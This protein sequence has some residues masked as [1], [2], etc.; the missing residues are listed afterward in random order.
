MA[1]TK[2][3]EQN[4]P[5]R[6][7][8]PYRKFMSHPAWKVLEEALAELEANDDLELTTA[9]RYVVGFLIQVLVEKGL[10]FPQ[11]ADELGK[12]HVKFQW[13]L[14]GN[15]S[16]EAHRRPALPRRTNEGVSA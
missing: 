15:V 14:I 3:Q 7:E 2:E 8:F 11:I 1:R 13:Q 12:T 9:S 10:T 5:V 6:D 4:A 16:Q